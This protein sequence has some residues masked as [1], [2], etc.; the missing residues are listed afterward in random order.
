LHSKIQ[1]NNGVT[2]VYQTL[3]GYQSVSVGAWIKTGSIHETNENN[4]VSHFIEHMLFKGTTSHSTYEISQIIDDLGGEIN[5]FTAK[6]CT[7]FYTKLLSN[8]LETGI[9]LLADMLGHSVFDPEAIE[10]ERNVIIDEINMYED[11]SE[12]V[13]D[14]L[15]TAL[16]FGSH[17]MALPI[18]GNKESVK[19][20]TRERLLD[21]FHRFYQP[22]AMVISVAG[23][24]DEVKMIQLMETYFGSL[25][26][27]RDLIV[28]EV[29]V[30]TMNWGFTCKTK[31]VEQ[32]QVSI[33]FPGI[34]YE[35]DRNYEMMLLSNIFGGTNSSMLFQSVR[36]QNGL[37]Y[38]IYAQ[39]SFYDYV[40]T[41]NVTFGA[42]KENLTQTL[43]CI[44][45]EIWKLRNNGITK[46]QIEAGKAH[47]KGSFL[48]GLEGTDHY[49]DLIGRIELFN[50]LEKDVPTM[51]EKIES[52][53]GETLDELIELCFGSGHC[54]MAVVGDIEESDA[55]VHYD[56]FVRQ[57]TRE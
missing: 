5:A 30:P 2:V 27:D 46:Q 51:I 37:S 24:F 17:A 33:D 42:S 14:D 39:P 8:D 1:L 15:L 41:L 28:P 56:E 3:E 31:D 25:E 22:S 49:M 48:L 6:D 47:L 35:D 43:N 45:E 36:E 50:H 10:T 12:D 20:L 9:E 32:V 52:I 26:N 11:S 23:A 34:S 44:A 38:G 7:C 54:A 57:L 40:G 18:L 53:T 16:V 4:G 13:V 55:K 29:E 19:G 21:Y